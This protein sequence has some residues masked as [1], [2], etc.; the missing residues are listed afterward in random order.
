MSVRRKLCEN[1]SVKRT[2]WRYQYWHGTTNQFDIG[3]YCWRCRT[4]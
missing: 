1:I 4:R 2:V 3:R